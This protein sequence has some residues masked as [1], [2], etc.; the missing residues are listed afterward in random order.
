MDTATARPSVFVSYNQADRPWA[1]WIAWTL[2]ENGYKA[3]I[4]AWDI[5]TGSNFVLEMDK[6]A[7]E[8]DKT[9]LVLSD[10]YLRSYFTQPEWAAAFARDPRGR[11]RKLIPVRV[12]ACSPDGLLAQIVWTD[13]FGLSEAVARERLLQAFAERGKPLVA[14]AFPGGSSREAVPFPGDPPIHNL[15]Y[16]RL[17]DLFTGR[18]EELDAL[19]GGGTAAITQN[20]AI[21]GLGGIGKT[22]LAV[23]YAW[24]AGNRYTAAWFVRADSPE[25]LRRNLAALTGPELLNLPEWEEQKEDKTVA[26]VKRWLREHAGWLMILDNVDTPEAAE[27]VLEVLP[28]LY[29]G[30]VLITSRLATWPPEVRKQALE[31]LSQEEAVR[32]LLQRTEGGRE[33][34]ADDSETAGHLAQRVDGLPLALEQAAAFIVRH[35]MRLADYLNSWESERQRVLQWFDPQV[36]RYPASVAVTWQHTFQQLT[37]TPAA[38]LRLTAF[39]APDP[40]PVEIFEQGTE[41]VEAAVGLFCEESGKAP[42]GKPIPEAVADLAGFS[43]VSQQDGRSLAVHRMVQEALRQQIPEGRRKSWIE[44]ALWIVDDATEGN[45]Q[46]FRTWP[47][48]DRLR[49][50][51]AQIVTWSDQEGIAEPTSR[52]MNQLGLLFLGKGLYS[53]AEPWLRRAL[54]IGEVAFG[55]AHT[56][57]ATYLNNLAQLL[58]DTTRLEEAEPLMRRAL[59]IGEAFFGNE[60]P[61]VARHLNNLALLLKDTTRLEEAE[62]LM[63]RALAIDETSFGNEH[64]KVAIRLNNLALLLMATNRLEEAESLMRRALAINEISSGSDHPDVAKHLNNLGR[65]LQAT[66][67]LE[68]AEPLMRRAVEIYE[69]SL[70]PDHPYT[71]RARKNLALLLAELNPSAGDPH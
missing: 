1:E 49:P 63:R 2:E 36:M 8:T 26:A 46:D 10:N 53:Q 51:A 58:K 4:Q 41:H 66:N 30:R 39:L 64:P 38:L 61:N 65:L 44:G 67:R 12:A 42:D 48:L 22:R 7:A 37:A 54:A 43:M 56:E 25:N 57:V 3:V 34:A 35:R 17:G 60:H 6:A 11:E 45:P 15:P 47:V 16:P 5:R 55:P 62:P 59:V 71:Q 9:L 20:A 33:P 27:A 70:D 29:K 31:K 18:Q 21:S 52:L 23:E 32:F 14:P 68:E 19:A 69:K 40:I 50:H 24:R 28:S 13:L